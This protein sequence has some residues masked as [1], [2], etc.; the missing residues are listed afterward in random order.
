MS[1]LSGQLP[2]GKK[3]QLAGLVGFQC[4]GRENRVA[5]DALEQPTC[6]LRNAK[7]HHSMQLAFGSCPLQPHGLEAKRNLKFCRSNEVVGQSL[8]PPGMRGFSLVIADCVSNRCLC[9]VSIGSKG[10]WLAENWQAR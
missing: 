2:K 1:L 3:W 7:P 9:V 8:S 5:A 4:A 6:L 10:N